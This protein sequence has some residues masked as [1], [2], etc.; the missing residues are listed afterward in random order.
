VIGLLLALG[1]VVWVGRRSW[2]VDLVAGAA[3]L[4][5]LVAIFSGEWLNALTGLLLLAWTTYS[6]ARA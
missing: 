5:G 4:G 6:M 3:L 2:F 1:V